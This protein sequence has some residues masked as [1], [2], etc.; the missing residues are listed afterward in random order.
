MPLP[1]FLYRLRFIPLFLFVGCSDSSA[2]V[3]DTLPVPLAAH[4]S[5]AAEVVAISKVPDPHST[6][7]PDCLIVA[8]VRVLEKAGDVRVPERLL[9]AL[10]AYLQ[11]ELQPAADLRAGQLCRLQLPADHREKGDLGMLQMADDIGKTDLPLYF[12]RHLSVEPRALAAFPTRPAGYF[13]TANSLLTAQLASVRYPWSEKAA[14]ERSAAIAADL[15]AIK[16]TLADHGGDWEQWD[17]AL[18][19]FH[20]DLRKKVEGSPGGKEM[21]KDRH[22]FRTLRNRD[23]KEVTA[24]PS[25]GPLNMITTLH[26]QLRERGIDLIVVPFPAKEM[27]NAHHFSEL[28]PKDG[29]YSVWR[30]KFTHDLLERGVEVLDLTSVLQENKAGHPWIFYDA[31]DLHPADGAIQIAAAEIANRLR[32]YDLDKRPEWPGIKYNRVPTIVTAKDDAQ[33]GAVRPG[34]Q[35]PATQIVA[36]DGSMVEVVEDSRSPVLIIGDS[37]TAVPGPQVP[38]ASIPS[39]LAFHLGEVPTQLISLGGSEKAM[40]MLAREGGGYLAGRAAVVFIFS[41]SRLLGAASFTGE[42]TWDLYDLPPIIL[43]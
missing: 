38:S 28:A 11:R 24:D 5:V 36:A 33:L 43:E 6:P 30:L 4:V 19:P 35:Y 17:K 32:R 40:R 14:A 20:E 23:Y 27:V 15:E 29:V 10:P 31:A 2:P 3:S 18:R 21:L 9:V 37:F 42:V 34:A 7:Y 41:P 13:A 39:H 16:T 1:V 12:T 8:E 25:R 26:R 22:Y